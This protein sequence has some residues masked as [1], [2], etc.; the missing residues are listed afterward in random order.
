MITRENN[1]WKMVLAIV[2]TLLASAIYTGSAMYVLQR[3]LRFDMSATLA[4][5]AQRNSTVRVGSF[6][7]VELDTA[8]RAERSWSIVRVRKATYRA[9]PSCASCWE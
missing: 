8:K 9:F 2:V 5:F 3:I 6:L 4:G 1:V 7:S